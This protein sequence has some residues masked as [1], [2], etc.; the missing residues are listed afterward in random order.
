MVLAAPRG[1]ITGTYRLGLTGTDTMFTV[2]PG[3]PLIVPLGVDGAARG[4]ATR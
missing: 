1:T 4:I 3:T 2:S